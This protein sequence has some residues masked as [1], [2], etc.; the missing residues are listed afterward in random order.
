MAIEIV[1]LPI[2]NTIDMLVYWMVSINEIM[3]SV[4]FVRPFEGQIASKCLMADTPTTH[5]MSVISE[6]TSIH[7]CAGEITIHTYYIII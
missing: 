4:D 1:D 3:I 7:I 2:K 6:W 5:L